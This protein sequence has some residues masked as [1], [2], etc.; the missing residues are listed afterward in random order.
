ML[1]ALS[2]APLG[3]TMTADAQF[4][5]GNDFLGTGAKGSGAPGRQRDRALGE[6]RD[7]NSIG[8]AGKLDAFINGDYYEDDAPVIDYSTSAC[9][10]RRPGRR[11]FC[12]RNGLVQRW[13]HNENL[14]LLPFGEALDDGG[15]ALAASVGATPAELQAEPLDPLALDVVF[16]ALCTSQSG[17]VD[18]DVADRQRA[19]F[20][21]P[22]GAFD[23]A[24]FDTALNDARKNVA[25]GYAV[26]PGLLRA[27]AIT[28]A[29]QLDCTTSCSTRRPTSRPSWRSWRRTA[30]CPFCCRR[31]GLPPRDGRRGRRPR[32]GQHAG[33]RRDLD[34]EDASEA[35]GQGRRRLQP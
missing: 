35:G 21:A 17:F 15:V 34:R 2:T 5:R 25:F 10:E 8:A 29:I 33:G 31:G 12:R 16:D 19:A 32:R 14:A 27:V 6:P 3:L 26:Y 23:A 4:A 20:V 24:A 22:S 30:C 28:V 9:I 7:R 18:Q 11:D 13:A 1:A